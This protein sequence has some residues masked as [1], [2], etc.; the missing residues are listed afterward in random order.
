MAK[1]EV[2]EEIKTAPKVEAV[3]VVNHVE[4]NLD[5][6]NDPRNQVVFTGEAKA[7]YG[8]IDSAKHANK[9]YIELQEK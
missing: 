4:V 5:G 6:P 2:K 8:D 3:E 7:D 9:T 1:K